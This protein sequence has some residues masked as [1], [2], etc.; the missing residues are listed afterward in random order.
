MYIFILQKCMNRKQ[1][2]GLEA[3]L[4]M[5]KNVILRKTRF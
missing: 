1:N 4:T 3:D 2:E 5:S